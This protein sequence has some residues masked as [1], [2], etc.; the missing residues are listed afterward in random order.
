MELKTFENFFIPT[1][2]ELDIPSDV[3][4]F[5][6]ILIFFFRCFYD[7]QYVLYFKKLY[8]IKL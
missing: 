7:F 3:S 1:D 2:I 5:S 6:G 8:R 4:E